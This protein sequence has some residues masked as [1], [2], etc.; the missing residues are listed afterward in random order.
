MYTLQP[1]LESND[2]SLPPLGQGRLPEVHFMLD[3]PSTLEFCEKNGFRGFAALGTIIYTLLHLNCLFLFPRL[4]WL[5]INPKFTFFSVSLT[6]K[7][8]KTAKAIRR[9]AVQS[10]NAREQ[11]AYASLYHSV[12][13]EGDHWQSFQST[14][15]SQS[16]SSST[17]QESRER[18]SG[19]IPNHLGAVAAFLKCGRAALAGQMAQLSAPLRFSYDLLLG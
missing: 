10:A 16:S 1:H 18:L 12:V 7:V 8:V 5:V 19:E 14:T 11:S 6:K 3:S 9:D 13:D 2:R 15:E 17:G 4:G